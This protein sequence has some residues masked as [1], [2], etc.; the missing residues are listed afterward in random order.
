M[1]KFKYKLTNG[2]TLTLE[3]D[4][5]PSDAEVEQHA[6]EANVTLQ[7]AEPEQKLTATHV[8]SEPSTYWGGVAKG[9]RESTNP[10][11][12]PWMRQGLDTL[13]S[14]VDKLKQGRYLGGAADLVKG[15][16]ATVAPVALP[17]AAVTAPLALAGGVVG[18]T[19]GSMGA[20]KA[21]EMA[22]AGEDVRNA[23]GV[24]GGIVGGGIGSA[25][26]PSE[27]AAGTA[28]LNRA[29]RMDAM[30]AVTRAASR[31]GAA[32]AASLIAGPKAGALVEA[33]QS[34]T[35]N[36]FAGNVLRGYAEHVQGQAVPPSPVVLPLGRRRA[37]APKVV[38]APPT[39]DEQLGVSPT[40]TGATMDTL[41]ETPP[42]APGRVALPLAHD[43]ARTEAASAASR[44]AADSLGVAAQPPLAPEPGISNPA[45]MPPA[46]AAG[47]RE[48]IPV[49]VRLRE[50]PPVRTA[51]PA[52][53]PRPVSSFE[54]MAR[55][56]GLDPEVMRANSG[57]AA[58]L[59][60]AAA[61]PEAVAETPVEASSPT[62]TRTEPALAG[63]STGKSAKLAETNAGTDSLDELLSATH[64]PDADLP[65]NGTGKPLS[66]EEL[67][68][69]R[70]EL[71]KQLMSR[72]DK[73]GAGTRKRGEG[74]TRP[75]D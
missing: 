33:V 74:Y 12:G 27:V 11:V 34:P 42:P 23:A 51:P 32:T 14:G 68:R 5:Q 2:K 56:L 36:R 24:A 3:G 7:P 50:S 58:A 63:E 8:G 66:P 37:A 72:W 48:R 55:R 21:A 18:G 69:I 41:P 44:E 35:L 28:L 6:R 60:E 22:G 25:V 1:P 57:E 52:T 13:A 43:A 9:M 30:P 73:P 53:P 67:L 29:A 40:S 20:D 17:F 39:L 16:G 62:N 38:K 54:D 15:A 70:E 61:V 31:H 47:S 26:M 65:T 59:P 10:V 71:A 19:V 4:E 49:P 46:A 45:Q 75:K 64:G